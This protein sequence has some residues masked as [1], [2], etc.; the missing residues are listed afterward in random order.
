VIVKLLLEKG[1]G[2]E[3]KDQIGWTALLWAAEKGH[4]AMVKLLFEQGAELEFKGL[5][6]G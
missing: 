6:D 1:A 5:A 2:L 3:S 4:G